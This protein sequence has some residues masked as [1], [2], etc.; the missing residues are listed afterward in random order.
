MSAGTI[1]GLELQPVV[2][3]ILMMAILFVLGM[4]MDW[5]GIL[6]LTMPIFVPIVVG[7]GYSPIWF[8]VVFTMNMQMSYL[9][10]PFGPAAFY[11]KGVAPEGITMGQIYNSFW[12]FIGFRPWP[13][14]SSSRFRRSPCGC[15]LSWVK[16]R[17][18]NQ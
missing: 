14:L 15:L 4:F 11:L 9:T 7:F 3:L 18:E 16:G 12:P 8:G 5:I 1:D 2:I 13:S 6:L 10:P 17:R